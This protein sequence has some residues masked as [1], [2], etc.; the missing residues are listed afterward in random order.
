MQWDEGEMYA[1]RLKEAGV[2]AKLLHCNGMILG[3]FSLAGLIR[4]ATRY[5]DRVWWRST[6]WRL[7]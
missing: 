1:S 4:R 3:F 5:F 7:D 2:P 6:G